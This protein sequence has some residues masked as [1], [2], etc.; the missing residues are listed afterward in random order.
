[1][2]GKKFARAFMALTAIVLVLSF[3]VACGPKAEK[4]GT[5]LRINLGTEPPHLDP[6]LATDSASINV[7]ANLSVGLTH[8]EPETLKVLPFLAESWETSALARSTPS[9]C[10]RTPNGPTASLSRL[11]TWSTVSSA[12]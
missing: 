6:A 2:F 7:L 10:A 11:A 9:S 8:F 12:P 1:M 3:V 5:E 4:L